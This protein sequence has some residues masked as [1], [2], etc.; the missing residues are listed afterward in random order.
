MMVDDDGERAGVDVV[1]RGERLSKAGDVFAEIPPKQN[2]SLEPNYLSGR[3]SRS[4]RLFGQLVGA[5]R[6][7]DS[8]PTTPLQ[9][10]EIPT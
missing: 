8:V 3:L 1:G 2:K 10:V 4:A 7:G 6:H 9:S 5:P